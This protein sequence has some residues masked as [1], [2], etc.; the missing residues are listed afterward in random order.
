MNESLDKSLQKLRELGYGNAADKIIEGF[1]AWDDHL[2]D[3]RTLVEK[4]VNGELGLHVHLLLGVVGDAGPAEEYRIK[5]HLR[6]DDP[7]HS[8]GMDV[9][10]PIVSDNDGVPT[11]INR[12]NRTH[13]KCAMLVDVVHLAELPERMRRIAIP[14]V[15]RLEGVDKCL[16]S[17]G[18][19]C[20]SAVISGAPLGRRARD[21]KHTLRNLGLSHSGSVFLGERK[22]EV[23]ESGA[24]IEQAIANYE[25]DRLG[26]FGS[27][28]DAKSPGDTTIDVRL[29]LGLRIWLVD[30]SVGF[31]VSPVLNF[32]VKALEVTPSPFALQDVARGAHK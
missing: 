25:G 9:I 2:T 11:F 22:G 27:I 32:Y 28:S 10:A 24:K 7:G 19:T 17:G 14:S 15:V 26:Q 13:C 21:R 30:D 29:G 12:S 31:S 3:C 4:Y 16:G 23:V 20:H 5:L 6:V 18:D 1:Q 8:Q